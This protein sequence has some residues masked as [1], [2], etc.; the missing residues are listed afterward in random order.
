MKSILRYLPNWGAFIAA[1]G[2]VISASTF[3]I[4]SFHNAGKSIRRLTALGTALTETAQ[5]VRDS[6]H[7]PEYAEGL[8]DRKKD[9]DARIVECGKPN[10][11]VAE[12]SENTRSVGASV[13]E[14]KPIDQPNAVTGGSNKRASAVFPR[15]QVALVGTYQQIAE[16]M[17]HCTRQRLPV[18]VVDFVLTTTDYRSEK[19]EL[20]LRAD[21][22][23]ESYQEL[24]AAAEDQPS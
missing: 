10:L 15:Y 13:L 1:I 20:M 16:F 4:A 11:V 22:T 21:V 19:N 5:T 8:L 2:L 3:A 23:V 24:K 12:I 18:R 14:I 9:L 17:K 6:T 7:T